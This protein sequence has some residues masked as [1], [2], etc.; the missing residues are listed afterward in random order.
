MSGKFD[1]Y[2]TRLYAEKERKEKELEQIHRKIRQN[3]EDEE[4]EEDLGQERKP[5]YKPRLGY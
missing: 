1:E 3:K 4:H 2:L 5:R